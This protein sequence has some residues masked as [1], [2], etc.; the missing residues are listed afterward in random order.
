MIS[1]LQQPFI[2][3]TLPILIGFVAIGIWQNKRLDDIMG[4]LG[5]IE[6]RLLAIEQRLC[7]LVIPASGV[8]QTSNAS[9]ASISWT[10]TIKDA[11]A[12]GLYIKKSKAAG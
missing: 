5:R 9:A 2:Q 3:V 8:L 11:A 1:L 6:D 12:T 4:R 10:G 7:L